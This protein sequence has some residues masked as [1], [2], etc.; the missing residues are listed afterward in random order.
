M[1]EMTRISKP[2]AANHI[3][4]TA[5]IVSAYLSNN[6]LSVADL[7]ALIAGTY[8]AIADLSQE[9]TRV[10]RALEK[11]TAAQIKKSITHD[12][13]TSFEDGKSYKTLRRHLTLR[14]L[15]VEAY[16]TKWGLPRDYPMTAASY[17]ARRAE[18]ARS[19]GLGQKRR[20]SF[21]KLTLVA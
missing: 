16:R 4:L 17:S 13:L 7:P 15:S 21:P 12:A 8:A 11:L 5:E 18:L 14:G 9:S 3:E 20:K 2:V 6:S 10:P 19:L 1:N